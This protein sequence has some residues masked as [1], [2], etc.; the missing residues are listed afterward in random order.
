MPD[1]NYIIQGE[2]LT[3]IADAIRNKKGSNNLIDAADMATE[4]D[5]IPTGSSIPTPCIELAD[6]E[7]A[8][9]L[10]NGTYLPTILV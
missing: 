3:D 8:S 4:I 7:Y 6:Y 1:T 10:G 9:G 5:S 2:T